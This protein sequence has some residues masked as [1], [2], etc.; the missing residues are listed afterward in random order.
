MTQ[1][2]NYWSC[3]RFADWIRGSVKPR[4]E[5]SKGW[6]DWKENAK[7]L[8]P[9]RFWLAEE[10]LNKAQDF[11]NWPMDRL[12]NLTNWINNRFV[13]Q[14]HVCR[15]GLKKGEWHEIS[16]RMLHGLF[17]E[18]ACFVSEHKSWM[19]YI[20]HPDKYRHLP[21]WK[22]KWP[23]RH[24]TD[25]NYPELGL[26]Y[27]EWEKGL[28]FNESWYG[29]SGR[30]FSDAEKANYPDYG[31]MTPQAK[32]AI[33]IG[34]LYNWWVNV[35]PKRPDPMDVSGWS[36]YCDYMHT[37]YGDAVFHEDRTDEERVM[38]KQALNKTHEIE[39]AYDDEDTVMMR[40]L[41]DIRNSLWT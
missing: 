24:F 14:T 35:R 28:V 10:F 21:F 16:E 31:Q 29:Y 8:K 36:A 20:S 39:Q 19:E 33:E 5:T 6:H 9:V 41:I 13:E 1:R 23:F 40:R 15:T 34:E 27:L 17:T 11:V 22:S 26:A 2:I 12:H 30:E 25:F 7:T 3:T 4:S 32:T 18:L 37:A 38:S